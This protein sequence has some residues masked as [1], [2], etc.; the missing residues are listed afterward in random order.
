MNPYTVER[1]D[2]YWEM[3]DIYEEKYVLKG[4]R[5]FPRAGILHPQA[6]KIA[7]DQ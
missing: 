3:R 5:G 4:P 2:M 1:R 7:Q 6:K